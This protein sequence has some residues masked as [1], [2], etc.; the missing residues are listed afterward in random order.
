MHKEKLCFN[1]LDSSHSIIN[2][3]WSKFNCFIFKIKHYT[4]LPFEEQN[5]SSIAIGEY[6]PEEST[7]LLSN[8]GDSTTSLLVHQG[9]FFLSTA[10][11]LDID[12]QI[13]WAYVCMAL[14]SIN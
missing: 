2:K 6:T 14:I 3:C 13:N 9:H 10:I 5:R 11:F 8:K 4:F 7:E 1:C 12:A